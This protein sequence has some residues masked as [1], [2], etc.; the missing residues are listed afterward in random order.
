MM[1]IAWFELLFRMAAKRI[2]TRKN[3]GMTCCY[4]DVLVWGECIRSEFYLIEI[5]FQLMRDHS[6]LDKFWYEKEN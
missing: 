1:L 4:L 2:S 6:K 5:Q 3:K